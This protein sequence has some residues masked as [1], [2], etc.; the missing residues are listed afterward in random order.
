MFDSLNATFW[1]FS[2]GLEFPH[3]TDHH[4]LVFFPQLH[5]WWEY[6]NPGDVVENLSLSHIMDIPYF[7]HSCDMKLPIVA[8]MKTLVKCKMM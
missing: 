1:L 8:D 6:H 4:S 7:A 3:Q 2:L 5:F